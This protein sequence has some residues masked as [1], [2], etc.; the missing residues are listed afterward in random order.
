MAPDYNKL[1]GVQCD[2]IN[3][4]MGVVLCQKCC[5]GVEHPVLYASQNIS[6]REEAYIAPAKI[7]RVFGTGGSETILLRLREEI[8]V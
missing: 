3:W 7:I 8:H 5:Q 2:A 4:G 6:I 1:F